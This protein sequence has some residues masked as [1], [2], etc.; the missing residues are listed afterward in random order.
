MLYAKRVYSLRMQN[1]AKENETL[2]RHHKKKQTKASDHPQTELNPDERAKS[3]LLNRTDKKKEK[4]FCL[5]TTFPR[6][7]HG[8]NSK[9]KL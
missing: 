4:L 7:K 9:Y 2:S 3:H 5:L 8:I 6:Y 1:V